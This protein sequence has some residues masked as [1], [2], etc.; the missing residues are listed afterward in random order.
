MNWLIPSV[1]ATLSGTVVLTLTFFYLYTVDRQKY[2]FIWSIGW[3]IYT[4]R[5]VL[6][7]V[8][9]TAGPDDYSRYLLISNQITTLLSGMF[10]M[11]GTFV[12]INRSMHRLWVYLA[13]AIGMWIFAC[14]MTDTTLLFLS[15]PNYLFIGMVFIWTGIMILRYRTVDGI[16][17]SVVGIAFIIWG[18]HKIDY[19][20][21]RPV[22]WFAP[23]GYLLGAFIEIIVAIGMILIYFQLARKE[24][25]QVFSMSL[26][27]LCIA[28][29]RT[30]TF[31]RINPA[32]TE[33]LGFTEDE[34][35]SKPFLEFIHPDDV[36]KTIDM[37]ESKLQKGERVINFINRYMCRD[38]SYRWL[39]WVSHPKPEKGVTYSVARDISDQKRAEDELRR[40]AALLEAQANTTT[41]GLLVVDGR[42]KKVFQNRRSIELWK[43]PQHIADNDDDQTQV[44]YVMNSTKDPEA[45]LAQVTFLYNHP[46]ETL[47]DEV[48]LKDGTVLERYSAPVV[49][50]DGQNYG[51]IWTF[52]DITARRRA[53]MENISLQSQLLQAQK[54]ES[55]GTLAGGIAHDFNNVLSPI[56]GYAEM[57]M[58]ITRGD[59]LQQK[60]ARAILGSASRASDLV[61]QILAF[62]RQR[63]SDKTPVKIQDI[64][65][66]V[67][68]LTRHS[69]PTSIEI[70][71]DIDSSCRPVMANPGQIHQVLMNLIVNAHHAMEADVG[72]IAIG[73]N[74][75]ELVGDRL[76][77]VEIAPG[78]YI[79]L[80]V[81]DTGTGMDPA[82]MMKIF[83]PFY[84]TKE[85]GKGTGL[86]LSVSYGIVREHEGLIDVSSTPGQGATFHVFLPVAAAGPEC[87]P[88]PADKPG[89]ANRGTE[90]ILLVD[91][92][93]SILDM[94]NS[95]LTG[96]GYKVTPHV[97]SP[98]ALEA[99]RNAP[100]TFDL[101]VTDMTMPEM[102]GVQLIAEIHKIR[103]R[104][105]VILCTGFNQQIDE[106]KATALGINAF[107]M[108]PV[109]RDQLAAAVRWVLDEC[110]GE[111]GT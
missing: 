54:M 98:L 19:P 61:K 53:E 82:V 38:G 22:E 106:K 83:D 11:Y 23:W 105:P 41:E 46:E 59:S 7:L 47:Q 63:Q 12:F 28:D 101:M 68:D 50:K 85:I 96:F 44:Q 58:E 60:Y 31:I 18:V 20:F 24:F 86:G 73:L 36:M 89:S 35:Q 107:L 14:G 29:I 108:K 40:Q 27:M 93:L 9:I 100:D 37:V 72:I 78:N 70:R 48:A 111:V 84:T 45:F 76:P 81:S 52:R 99:F 1:V 67:L 80:S 32:F 95:L 65:R 74:E 49:G 102:T 97:G 2:L 33:T 4:L 43:I 51:R 79:D 26:D 75:I 71:A 39:S 66:E 92:E 55:I 56:V 15:L 3:C 10:L 6:M 90:H 64:I 34:L 16:L 42:G 30:S 103:P 57:L 104:L 110:A 88:M 77:S 69:I 21:L 109:R 94:L 87:A 8:L 25:E 62:S 5:F 17:P 13:V 91:D